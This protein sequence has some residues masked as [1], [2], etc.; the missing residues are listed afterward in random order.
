MISLSFYAFLRPGE[1]TGE[2]HNLQFEDVTIQDGI[3]H[4]IFRHYKH[5]DGVP[6]LLKVP[7]SNN[8]TC[9]VKHLSHFL[10][11]RNKTPGPLFCFKNGYYVSYNKYKSVFMNLASFLTVKGILSPHSARIGAASYAA[12]IGI[13]ESRIRLIGRWHT[14]SYLRYIR[15]ISM[16]TQ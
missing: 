3:I 12:S 5:S 16:S 2:L 7:P 11:F 15:P 1:V 14:N 8:S 10:L 13:P 9:P 4:I 6:F